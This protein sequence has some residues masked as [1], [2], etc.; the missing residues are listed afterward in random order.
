MKKI[1]VTIEEHLTQTF[2]IEAESL[3][4][5]MSVA[6]EKYHK[7]EIALEPGELQSTIMC[8][9]DTETNDTTDWMVI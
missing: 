3:E 8:A 6:E 1:K 5:A 2:E 7:G 4:D 9:V